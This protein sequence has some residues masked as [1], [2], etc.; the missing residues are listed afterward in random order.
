MPN[1]KAPG[2][3]RVG[4][5]ETKVTQKPSSTITIH[6][7]S[8]RENKTVEKDSAERTHPAETLALQRERLRWED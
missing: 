6:F 7:C 2:Y 5:I 8:S 1:S 4:K 3:I